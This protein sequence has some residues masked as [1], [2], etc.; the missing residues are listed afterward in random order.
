MSPPD[1]QIETFVVGPLQT[2]CYV[3]TC[4]KDC[5]VI[6]PAPWCGK[7]VRALQRHGRQ[8]SR[9]LLTHGHADHIGG[10]GKLSK[11]FA[12]ATLCCPRGDEY[13]L[14]D[15]KANMSHIFLG[16][17]TAPPAEELLEP[18]Q[19]LSCGQS[20]WLVLDTAGHTPGG[21]SYYCP[22]AAVVLTGDA[23]FAGSI[24]RTDIPRAS[25]SQLVRNILAN[26]MGL[27][28]ETRVLPGHGPA[29][30]I[31]AER[32]NNPFIIEACKRTGLV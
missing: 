21:V 26:L 15:S 28:D 22:A 11:T 13:M 7:V 23:L 4:G 9:I 17:L 6:D 12:D 24:G 3:V 5:W 18:G 27:P 29:S 1:V 19:K 25:M 2:N 16:G 10:V 30:T 20:E 8:P 14:A 31:G 32:Q